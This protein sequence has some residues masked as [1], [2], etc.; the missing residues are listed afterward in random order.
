MVMDSV[1]YHNMYKFLDKFNKDR[2][3][4]LPVCCDFSQ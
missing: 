1:G 4:T 2:F 3:I